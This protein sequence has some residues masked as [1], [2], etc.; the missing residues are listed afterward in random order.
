MVVILPSLLVCACAV[1]FDALQTVSGRSSKGE[2]YPDCSIANYSLE[3]VLTYS[4]QGLKN[5][6]LARLWPSRESPIDCSSR[7]QRVGG[8]NLEY[9]HWPGG[10]GHHVEKNLQRM[11]NNAWPVG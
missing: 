4:Y 11:V 7:A 2:G 6:V 3:H 9:S 10:P 8:H 5:S 1:T